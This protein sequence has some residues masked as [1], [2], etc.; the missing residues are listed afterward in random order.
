MLGGVSTLFWRPGWVSQITP[1]LSCPHDVMER[2]LDEDSESLAFCFSSATPSLCAWAI[3]VPAV[4]LRSP[5]RVTR[6]FPFCALNTVGLLH[7]LILAAA[8]LPLGP[9]LSQASPGFCVL[10]DC[11][12][13]AGIQKVEPCF[14]APGRHPLC[15]LPGA[16]G[17][18]TTSST[19]RG[20]RS[21]LL[22]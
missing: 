20:E 14:S 2:A 15:E 17:L 1:R 9:H 11:Q 7:L 8:M 16:T 3:L 22:H 12:S 18:G 19:G 10:A 5:F 13:G 4:A 6:A 21:G